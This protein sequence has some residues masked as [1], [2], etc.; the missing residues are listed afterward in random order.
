MQGSR[1]IPTH[2]HGTEPPSSVDLFPNMPLLRCPKLQTFA[3]WQLL[4]LNNPIN[5]LGV[6][7]RIKN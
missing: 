3:Q 5:F 4:P 7:I 2:T 6:L 1:S